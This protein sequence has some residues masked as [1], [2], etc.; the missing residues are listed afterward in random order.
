M[1][2]LVIALD[3]VP[4]G[5]VAEGR[6]LVVAP[7][8]NSWFR[9]WASDEDDARRRAE[10]VAETFVYLLGRDGIH[11]EARVG[12]ADPVIAIADA[13][14]TFAADEIVVTGPW[15][16]SAEI[17]ARARRRFAL[18]TRVANTLPLAA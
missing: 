14:P 8:L 16:Q 12:D 2:V 17:A 1:N 9:R 5:D 6:I 7:A 10:E 15:E 18:P 13:L 3:G 4:P 11:A